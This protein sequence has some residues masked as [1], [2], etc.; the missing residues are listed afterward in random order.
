MKVKSHKP[1]AE[2]QL[3]EVASLFAMLSEPTRLRL[4]QVLQKGPATV[5]AIMEQT[6]LKQANASRQLALLHQAGIL[7]RQ[8]FANTVR[9]QIQ[10]PL[11]FDLCALVCDSLR[12][13]AQ[14][15]A[16]LLK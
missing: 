15:K 12:Q 9:Y 14:T 3:R 5:G 13:E 10:M 1:L 11:V 8:K 16:R 2:A 7:S 4:I 6:G